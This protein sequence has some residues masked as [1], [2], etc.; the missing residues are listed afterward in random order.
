MPS[1]VPSQVKSSQVNSS[2]FKSI[3]VQSSFVFG[4]HLCSIHCTWVLSTLPPVDCS[5]HIFVHFSDSFQEDISGKTENAD[6]IYLFI[7]TVRL[8]SFVAIVSVILI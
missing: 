3:Q 8:N 6:L 7:F 4:Y 2:Q 5:L 1:L